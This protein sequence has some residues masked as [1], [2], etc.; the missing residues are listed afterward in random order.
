MRTLEDL[1]DMLEEQIKQITKKGD[2]TPTELESAYKAVDILKDIEQIK[3][4]GDGEESGGYSQ[5]N[6][7]NRGYSRGGYANNAYDGPIWNQGQGSNDGGSYGRGVYMGSYDGGNYGRS[8]DEMSNDYSQEG[9][10]RR[11]RDARTGRFVSRDA[12]NSRDYSR[13]YY[14]NDYSR[15]GDKEQMV[16][17]LQEMM[18]TAS[19]EKERRA[20]MQCLEQL[21]E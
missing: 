7:S 3:N 14:S 19:S 4:M 1:K 17:K 2:I 15:H 12:G 5:R 11:G 8:Y 16:M 10:Y 13:D 21:E 9:S 18:R 20:I 6:Y